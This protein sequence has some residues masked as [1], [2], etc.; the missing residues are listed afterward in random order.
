M[1]LNL[2][3]DRA[4]KMMTDTISLKVLEKAGGVS[5]VKAYCKEYQCSFVWIKYLNII[6]TSWN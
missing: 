3:S 6:L 2:K 5:L 1:F 4:V